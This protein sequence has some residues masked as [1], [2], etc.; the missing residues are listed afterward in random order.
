M[1][2]GLVYKGTTSVVLFISVNNRKS[3][4][5]QAGICREKNKC[6][7]RVRKRNLPFGEVSKS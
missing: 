6:F 3:S 5:P 1:N 4:N 2:S 7:I